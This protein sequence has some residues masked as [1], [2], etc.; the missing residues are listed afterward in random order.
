MLVEPPVFMSKN[1]KRGEGKAFFRNLAGNFYLFLSMKIFAKALMIT[2][3]MV[4]PMMVA[5]APKFSIEKYHDEISEMSVDDN[6]ASPEV[7]KK[8]L[9][10]TKRRMADLASRL[11]AAGMEADTRERGGLVVTVSMPVAKVFAPN[12]TIISPAGVTP[13]MTLA[14]HLKTPDKYKLL[15]TVHSDDT[16]TEAYLNALTRARAE[17]IVEWFEGRGLHTEGIVPYGMGFDEPLSVEPSRAGRAMNRRIEFYFV[18][19]PVMIDNVKA[20]RP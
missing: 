6:L 3:V 8:Q 4:L 12:D 9:E 20:G 13:L 18:P 1:A 11:K 15:V 5:A 19:G 14:Q 7:P 16:G 10:E 17:A 2:G